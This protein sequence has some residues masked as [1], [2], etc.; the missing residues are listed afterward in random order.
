MGSGACNSKRWTCT[1]R[2]CVS[3]AAQLVG[4]SLFIRNAAVS[5]TVA[6]QGSCV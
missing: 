4:R 5:S 1:V 6:L 2:S 3:V